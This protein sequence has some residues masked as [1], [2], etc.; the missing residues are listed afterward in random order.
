M[1]VGAQ[2][3]VLD[4]PSQ[5]WPTCPA[6]GPHITRR[7]HLE[8]LA[9]HTYLVTLRRLFEST[10]DPAGLCWTRGPIDCVAVPVR[11]GITVGPG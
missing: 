5:R 7:L 3:V 6:V 2:V 4:E 8:V 10:S 11:A 9:F 1:K